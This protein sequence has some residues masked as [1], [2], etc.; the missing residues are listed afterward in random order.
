[1]V[2]VAHP[3]VASRHS[4]RSVAVGHR[5]VGHELK[6]HLTEALSLWYSDCDG[7][8]VAASRV[9]TSGDIGIAQGLNRGAV[10]PKMGTFEYQCND[11][12]SVNIGEGVCHSKVEC[13]VDGHSVASNVDYLH[14]VE[15]LAST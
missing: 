15:G 4:D 11:T 12:S 2:G 7:V 5:C 13:A 10:E 1:M 9:S 8:L 14:I 6:I 3:V